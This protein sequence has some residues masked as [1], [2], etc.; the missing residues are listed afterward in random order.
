M[1]DVEGRPVRS[2]PARRG[3]RQDRRSAPRTPATTGRRRRSRSSS[4]RWAPTESG[5]RCARRSPASA[6]YLLSKVLGLNATQESTLGLIFHWAEQSDCPLLDLK[7]LRAVISHLTSDEGKADLKSLGGVSAHDG[8]RH[9]AGAGQPAR[10]R[11]ATRSSASP[12]LRPE[13]PAARR[14]PRAA[15]SSRCSSSAVSRR[16]R[17]MFSTFLMWVLADLFDATARGR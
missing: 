3:Q 13:R 5:C 4:C 12:K 11:A 8:G 15:A 6:R 14:R 17:C 7:D 1:A 10:P 9:P 16:A 2:V